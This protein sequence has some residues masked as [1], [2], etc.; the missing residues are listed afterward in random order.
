MTSDGYLRY[1]HVRHDLLTFVAENDVWL[2]DTGGGRAYRLSVDSCP[3]FTPRISPD[4]S[5]VAWATRRDGA[6]E[7]HVAPTD[8]GVARRLTHW[9]QPGS[10]VTGWLSDDEVIVLSTTGEAEH[11]RM[12]AHAVPVDG[13]PSRRLPYGWA[14]DLA[15]GPDGRVLLSSYFWTEPA[16]WKRYRGGTASQLWL[17]LE[18]SGAFRRIFADLASSLAFPVWTVGEDGRQRIAFCSDHEGS[19]QLYSAVVGRRRPTTAQLTRRTD[20]DFYVRHASSDGRQV[21][22]CAG[23]DVFLLP[24]LDNGVEPH[25]VDIR[26]G[27]SR[28]LTQRHRV[29]AAR[30]LGTIGTDRTGRASAV[31]SR[32]TINW[33]THR[34]GPVRALATG[35]AVRRRLPVVLDDTTGRLGERRSRR[36]RPRGHRPRRP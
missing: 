28:P 22:Y 26:I 34:G 5:L 6:S 12:Y 4:G 31:E 1:P 10:R 27:S 33:V 7:V 9:G 32:G 3:A 35:S 15:F 30:H 20:S 21:V 18:G 36:R 14:G 29:K 13:G 19:G 24:S 11:T 25:R 23:G 2:A 16:R 8:G 17:D